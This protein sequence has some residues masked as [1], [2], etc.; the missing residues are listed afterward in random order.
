MFVC[1]LLHFRSYLLLSN[2]LKLLSTK[3]TDT[4]EN[5][6][7]GP[8]GKGGQHGGDARERTGRG[9]PARAGNFN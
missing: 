9:G 1:L 6:T 4:D 3:Q 5:V 7:V 2:L 8:G